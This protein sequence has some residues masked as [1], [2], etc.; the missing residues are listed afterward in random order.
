MQGLDDIVLLE[1]ALMHRRI[2]K[3]RRMLAS[4][5][6]L[7]QRLIRLGEKLIDE[8]VLS[9]RRH[10]DAGG[11]GQM[12]LF[13]DVWLIQDVPEIRQHLAT[14]LV[15][16][17]CKQDGEL[18][19]AVT[20]NEALVLHRDEAEATGHLLQY[21]IAGAV[22]EGIIQGFKVIDIDQHEGMG[23]ALLQQLLHAHIGM[24]PVRQLCH[25]IMLIHILQLVSGVG[26]L[27]GRAPLLFG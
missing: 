4:A 11:N 22:A 5:L 25:R 23:A 9:G 26:Q 8:A 27:A 15:D 21:I 6:R 12:L 10:T 20:G 13:V 14:V 18:I 3:Y 24:A 1:D 16:F 19:T 7:C 17:I 2:E